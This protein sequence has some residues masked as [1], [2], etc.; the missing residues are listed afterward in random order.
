[1]VRTTIMLKNIPNKL[2]DVE[3]MRFIEEVAGQ[4]WDVVYVRQDW[5]TGLNVGYGFINFIDTASLLRFAQA[6]IGT[7]WNL[8]GSDKLCIAS[9]ANIQGKASLIA[10]FRNSSVLDQEPSRR[11]KLFYS[12]GP[13]KG[14]PEPF[15]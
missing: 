12:S 5:K 7:R 6:R 4:C 9:Y 11:P 3:V 10:H 14:Q 2:G 1:D 13:F 15:P 8:C